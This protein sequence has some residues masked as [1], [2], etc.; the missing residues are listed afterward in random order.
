M[1]DVVLLLLSVGKPESKRETHRRGRDGAG[2]RRGGGQERRG[3][4]GEA[5]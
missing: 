4:N 1:C 5:T 2:K 3:S